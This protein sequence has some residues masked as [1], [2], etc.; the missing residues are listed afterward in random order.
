MILMKTTIAYT[1]LS[2]FIISFP[3]FLIN[4]FKDRYK[5]G[6]LYIVKLDQNRQSLAWKKRSVHVQLTFMYIYLIVYTESIEY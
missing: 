1:K 2:S 3:A 5:F 6:S 4:D